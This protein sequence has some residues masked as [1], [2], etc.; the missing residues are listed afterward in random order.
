MNNESAIDPTGDEPGETLISDLL[1]ENS[2]R[3]RPGNDGNCESRS[4]EA[5][6]NLPP[7]AVQDDVSRKPADSEEEEEESEEEEMEGDDDL[8]G[9]MEFGSFWKANDDDVSDAS[10]ENAE[11]RQMRF[12][13]Q[14][15]K[16]HSVR[17]L[18]RNKDPEL[19]SSVTR[20]RLQHGQ[21][22]AIV[23]LIG[24]AHFSEVSNKEVSDLIEAVR[25]FF[26]NCGSIEMS[27]YSEV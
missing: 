19:P 7:R 21:H 16:Y 3:T 11:D 27:L 12:L 5:G 13:R 23:Y 22:N 15:Q 4:N 9:E 8:E 18:G 25:L 1:E 17:L 20:L 6:E 26:T 14:Q 10:S 2:V 24:T